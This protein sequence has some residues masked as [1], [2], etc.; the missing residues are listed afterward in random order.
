MNLDF[1]RAHCMSLPATTEQIQWKVD[2][3]FKIGGK[4]YCVAPT[5]GDYGGPSFKASDDDFLELIEREGIIPA[6]YLARAKWVKL[7]AFDTLPRAE[8]KQHLTRAYEL[9]KAGLSKKVQAELDQPK[10]P[11]AKK[12]HAAR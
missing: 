12:K 1:I 5:E 4:M 3:V 2:L 9:V 10:K 6:P 8:L 7:E 11:A